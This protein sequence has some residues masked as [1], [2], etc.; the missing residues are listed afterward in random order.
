[1][2]KVVL[3][4][5]LQ[6]VAALSVASQPFMPFASTRM[7]NMINL[8]SV[9]G[10]GELLV[11]LNELAEG[12]PILPANHAINPAEHLF[13][14]IPDEV[15]QAQIDKLEATDKGNQSSTE[16]AE[17]VP[18]TISYQPVKD[19]IQYDDFAKMD[20]RTGTVL[21]AEKVEKSK[22]LLKLQV[23]LGFETR[24]ILSGIAEHFSPE[25]V[26]GK[27]VVVLA[28]LAPRLMMGTE[29]QGMILMAED[30]EGKLSF[31]GP[32]DGWPNG[33]GVK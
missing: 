30:A 32:S 10:K 8:R 29:S 4:L 17:S 7:R 25:Q 3:N 1:M 33:M 27:Q 23:D 12:N 5:G 6:I 13:S 9:S 19:V 14:R 11:S 26:V 28:N 20:I 24:T 16:P 22:K 31:V 15:I 2:V 18:A 21:T